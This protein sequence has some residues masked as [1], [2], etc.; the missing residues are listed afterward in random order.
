MLTKRPYVDIIGNEH[1]LSF[2][3]DKTLCVLNEN[4]TSVSTGGD[5]VVDYDIVRQSHVH[6][7]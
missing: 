7:F 6:F 5:A 2:L 3:C 1:S 4:Y